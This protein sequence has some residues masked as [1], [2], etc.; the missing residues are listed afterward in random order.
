VG[1]L[2]ATAEAEAAITLSRGGAPNTYSYTEPN[3][4]TALFA[5]GD[6]GALIAV[7]DG[8]FGASGSEAITEFLLTSCAERWTGAEPLGPTERAWN[9][10]ALETV[11]QCGRTVLARAAEIGVPPAPSTLSIALARPGEG[12]LFWLSAGDSHVFLIEEPAT[13]DVGWPSLGHKRAYYLGY[14]AAT[15]EGMADTFA[16][17]SVSLSNLCA[18]VLAT[19]G[20]SEPG[21]GFPDPEAAVHQAA[22]ETAQSDVETR[23]LDFA[24]QL[25]HA[26][27]EI[28]RKQRAGDNL[29]CAVLDFRNPE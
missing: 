11:Y 1:S 26:T 2:A 10:I 20:L 21:I 8:H 18:V 17:G 15:R 9:E 14:E 12:T 27:L 25:S 19:D 23:P 3:E 29:A 24:K 4:D 5:L 16:C 7:A 28:Q 13:R 6:G 22:A